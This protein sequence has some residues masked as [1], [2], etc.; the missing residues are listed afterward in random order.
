MPFLKN[1]WKKLAIASGIALAVNFNAHADF[2]QFDGRHI[3]LDLT[4]PE[5]SYNGVHGLFSKFPHM[6]DHLV[7]MKYRYDQQLATDE[8]QAVMKGWFD[9]IEHMRGLPRDALLEK[10]DAYVNDYIDYKLDEDRP[11]GNGEHFYTPIETIKSKEGDCEDYALLKYFSLKYLGVPEEEM[12]LTHLY[13]HANLLVEGENDRFYY[14][15]NSDWISFEEPSEYFQDWGY[16]DDGPVAFLNFTDEGQALMQNRTHQLLAKHD[17]AS[18]NPWGL[19]ETFNSILAVEL[20]LLGGLG[21]K[22]RRTIMSAIR[23]RRSSP[24]QGQEKNLTL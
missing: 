8:G 13:R 14:L 5:H 6:S 17:F 18:T 4:T 24:D 15:D 7:Y 20:L 16:Y 1:K 10:L 3:Q 21:I 9:K 23:R 22:N 12:R 2:D 11:E 19:T